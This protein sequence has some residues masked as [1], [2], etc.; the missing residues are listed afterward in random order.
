MNNSCAQQ[1]SGIGPNTPQIP[2]PSPYNGDDT[3]R[4]ARC[5]CVPQLGGLLY[6][7]YDDVQQEMPSSAKGSTAPS[8]ARKI[9][10]FGPLW[11]VSG[12]TGTAKVRRR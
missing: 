6:D 7:Q 3:V 4:A 2:P 9:P 5:G 12:A 10:L 11:C 1:Q 8:W